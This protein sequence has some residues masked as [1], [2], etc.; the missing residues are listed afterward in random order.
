LKLVAATG[1]RENL[2][3]GNRS[4]RPESFPDLRL[5]TIETDLNI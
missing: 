1:R 4:D 5:A 3:G 2:P